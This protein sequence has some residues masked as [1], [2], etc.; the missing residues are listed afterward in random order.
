MP[1]GRRAAAPLCGTGQAPWFLLRPRFLSYD[2]GSLL[3]D[4]G[5][6]NGLL[7]QLEKA[8]L[9]YRDLH[10]IYVTHQHLDHL[11]GIVWLVRCIGMD[12]K[13][14]KDFG[15]YTI[16]AHRKLSVV[17]DGICRSLLL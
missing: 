3:V 2:K 5:G 15:S 4:G 14:G 1:E 6:G 16:Y 17:L 12:V 13:N 8:G 9:S 10:T 11:M 7:L